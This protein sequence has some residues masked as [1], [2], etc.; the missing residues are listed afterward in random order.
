[1]FKIKNLTVKN[2]MS[3]GNAT[4]GLDFDRSDL[5]LVLGVN[6]DLGGDDSGARN[7]TGKTTIINALSYALYGG[8]LT[9]IRR[10][11]LINK[12][13]G[14]N[15]LVTVDFDH[16]DIS[17]KIER[18]RKPNIMKFFVSG[19]EQEITNES[20]GDSRQTQ[21]QIERMLGMSSEM[22][23]HIVALN[24]Y[25]EPFLSLKAKDQRDI[26]EQLLGI[27]ILSEKAEAL[28]EQNKTTK[29]EIIKEE[30]K[31][32]ALQE[33]NERI[34]RQLENLKRRQ[35][36]W[37]A[38]HNDDIK[39]LNSALN[40]LK[41][42]DIT[43]EIEQHKLLSAYKQKEK[44]LKDISDAIE[45]T[46]ININRDSERIERISEDINKLEDHTCS[47]CGQEFH[48]KRQVV[49]TKEKKAKLKII[50]KEFKAY[51]KELVTLTT[52]D[53]ELG[54]L[55]DKPETFYADKRDAFEHRASLEKLEEQ[56]GD[57][58][59][60]EDPYNDQINE[61]TEQALAEI[62]YTLMNELVKVREHQDFLLKL[63]T[64][65]DSFVRK[66]IIEQNL[67]YLNARLSQY[68]DRIGLPHQVTF[69]NDLTVEIQELG[70]ELDF[71][72]L[73]R[74]ERNRLILSLSWAFRDVWE[75]LYNPINLLFID[76][77]VDSG[78]DGSGVEAA[79]AILKKMS[80]EHN[81]SIWLVSHKDEL[82]G[83]VNN[84]MTVT[85]ENG[86]TSYNTDVD[87]I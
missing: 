28:K 6:I 74:G 47:T 78:M 55:G 60:E 54:K 14:K 1:M 27:T 40:E 48:D 68:L 43:K 86:F 52:V 80:R 22:F 51:E 8:A 2:F 26:I 84:V 41:K 33:A 66:R 9:N 13:N 72:N 19:Q 16:N 46:Q 10:D 7:G 62:E 45:R 32:K 85:K 38:K 49:V 58:K 65:K 34:E 35:T 67:S 71:D 25:T 4:Q 77:L 44:D 36:L 50:K 12:T 29:D 15:M 53:K 18:G 56:L 82:S 76:E 87:I 57:K 70:R 69:L 63:L 24:T 11:N 42:I 61:M 59:K 39:E 79:M 5:T 37:I 17:Y 81:K 23:K 64:N 3:V 75:S 83:R 73:S 31:I 21:A 20:Q 30:F